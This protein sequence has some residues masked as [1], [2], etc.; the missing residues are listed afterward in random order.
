MES[1]RLTLFP[2]T[3]TS[4]HRANADHG[5][6][7][8]AHGKRKFSGVDGPVDL[9][10]PRVV[11]SRKTSKTMESAGEDFSANNMIR[12][13][14]P[15]PK[16]PDQIFQCIYLVDPEGIR[17]YCLAQGH[18]SDEHPHRTVM[19]RRSADKTVVGLSKPVPNLLNIIGVFRFASSLFT[20]FDRPGFPLSEIA[21]S[22]S[23]QLGVAQIKTISKEA[24]RGINF[25]SDAGFSFVTIRLED[26]TVSA[27]DGR[28]ST[29]PCTKGPSQVLWRRLSRNC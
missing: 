3:G 28:N 27:Y 19:I 24:L 26:I 23:P 21:V 10:L 15:I 1:R 12:V 16:N 6:D 11:E 8:F 18:Y 14:T 7:S 2:K 17:P 4:D 20:V 22:Q 9:E 5:G 29:G 13:F 25:L